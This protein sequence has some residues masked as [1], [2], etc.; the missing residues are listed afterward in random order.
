MIAKELYRMLSSTAILRAVY[1]YNINNNKK[2]EYMNASGLLSMAVQ[3]VNGSLPLTATRWPEF[4][5]SFSRRIYI[6][7]ELF[8]F[9]G[10]GTLPDS[11]D[12]SRDA[13]RWLYY[14][15]II[16]LGSK[17]GNEPGRPVPSLF[18]SAVPIEQTIGLEV[19]LAIV[20]AEWIDI[21]IEQAQT[22]K[23][24]LDDEVDAT[25]LRMTKQH[26][27]QYAF[28]RPYA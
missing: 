26:A 25:V 2:R 3:N 23:K 21:M 19:T 15:R 6:E 28:E 5:G 1:E 9:L 18:E 16:F 22:K 7:Q 20:C 8:K 27:W 11:S 14:E 12:L 4:S 17:I 13:F 24:N 10:F